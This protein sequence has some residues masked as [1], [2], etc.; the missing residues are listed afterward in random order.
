MSAFYS[1]LLAYFLDIYPVLRV[2]CSQLVVCAMCPFPYL[3]CIF[4]V[5]STC[6]IG[7]RWN[8]EEWCLDIA[9][10]SMWSKYKS[11]SRWRTLVVD[12]ILRVNRW[13]DDHVDDDLGCHRDTPSMECK[14]RVGSINKLWR[15]V[16]WWCRHWSVGSIEDSIA[17]AVMPTTDGKQGSKEGEYSGEGVM[18]MVLT[19]QDPTPIDQERD[20]HD[21]WCLLSWHEY[22]SEDVVFVERRLRWWMRE[23]VTLLTLPLP[24]LISTF[25]HFPFVFLHSYW[26]VQQ[27]HI[28]N[29]HSNSLGTP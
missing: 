11:V 25:I 17:A 1:S 13:N 19:P 8:W 5:Y 16:G 29:S 10:F 4:D 21:T 14:D 26:S 22:V 6:R 7:N 3:A 20:S 18:M 15:S 28:H 2:N 12:A 24:S 9:R 27:S 23:M